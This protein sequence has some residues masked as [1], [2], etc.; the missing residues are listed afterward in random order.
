[1]TLVTIMVIG[2][3]GGV[4]P[5]LLEWLYRSANAMA[6]AFAAVIGLSLLVRRLTRVRVER[7]AA[8]LEFQG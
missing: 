8:R 4:L 6:I 2:A 1:M 7:Q 5:F 3:F